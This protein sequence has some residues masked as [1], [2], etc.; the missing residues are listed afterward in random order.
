MFKKQIDFSEKE[1]ALQNM[2][3]ARDELN[4]AM[5]MFN[6]ATDEYFEIANTELTI[7][8][9]KYNVAIQKLKKLCEDKVDIP[10]IGIIHSYATV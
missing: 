6:Y 10:S 4:R 1:M 5:Q 8:E 2:L 3:A 9:L 7:A